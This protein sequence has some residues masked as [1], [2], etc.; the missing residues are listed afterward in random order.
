MALHPDGS[1]LYVPQP[2][3]VNIYNALTGALLGSITSPDISGPTGICLPRCTAPVI[4]AVTVSTSSLW[5]PNHKMVDITVGYTNTSNC[6][7]TCTLSVTSN[8]SIN[9]TGDGDTSPDWVVVDATHVQL[10][11][12][13]SGLGTGRTYTITI[14]CTNSAGQSSTATATVTVRHDQR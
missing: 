6:P 11:A 9:G 4:S 3:A 8:E 14:T 5:P 12:E 2:G 13:R 1:K 7:S 10:R